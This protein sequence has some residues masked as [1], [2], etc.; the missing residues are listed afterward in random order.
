[1][2]EY[3]YDG[4]GFDRDDQI[5]YT[6]AGMSLRQDIDTTGMKTLAQDGTIGFDNALDVV[7]ANEYT[8]VCQFISENG[9]NYT[10]LRFGKCGCCKHD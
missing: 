3:M 7:N 5:L 9:A 6:V 4:W 2:L 10:D 1:M 8:E